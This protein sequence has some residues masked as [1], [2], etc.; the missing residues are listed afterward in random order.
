M[1]RTAIILA[2]FVL[3]TNIL[4]QVSREAAELTAKGVKHYEAGD[5]NLALDTLTKAIDVSSRPK[6]RKQ[7]RPNSLIESSDAEELRNRITFHDPV[8][9]M[10]FLNRGHVQFARAK[11]DLA[12]ADYSES[13]RLKPANAEALCARSTAYLVDQKMSQALDDARRAIKVEPKFARG[14]LV[15]AMAFYGL[16]RTDD[17]I[18]AV[19]KAIEL[20]P[21]SSEAFFRRGDLLRLALRYDEAMADYDRANAIDRDMASPYI[22]RGAIRFEQRRY[23]ESIDHYSTALKLD[24]RLLQ[25]LRF[26]GYAYLAIG[27]DFEASRDFARVLSVAPAFREEIETTSAEIREK[28]KL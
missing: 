7:A 12:I 11:M 23:Q 15:M 24:P 16:G 8:T 25:A 6:T 19:N 26:R 18:S 28:R 22:G 9:A 10:A 20:D 14:H 27:K 21:E 13:I 2:I 3:S 5:L 17:A 4:S 1:K